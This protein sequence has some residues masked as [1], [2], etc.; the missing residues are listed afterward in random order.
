MP[1][2][3]SASSTISSS[4]SRS[5]LASL[6]ALM[7][8]LSSSSASPSPGL[9]PRRCL[10]AASGIPAAMNSSSYA[11]LLSISSKKLASSKPPTANSFSMCSAAAVAP[12]VSAPRPHARLAQGRMWSMR[13]A[14]PP[15]HSAWL[16]HQRHREQ[17]VHQRRLRHAAIII[18]ARSQRLHS[19]EHATPGG[20]ATPTTYAPIWQV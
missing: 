11:S 3:S 4:I 19:H 16:L 10:G 8:S 20:S 17:R 14:P 2:C 12:R 18:R 15:K 13:M 5:L 6:A 1:T 7:S 9:A